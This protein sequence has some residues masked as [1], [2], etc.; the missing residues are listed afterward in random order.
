M[1]AALEAVRSIIARRTES[2][3]PREAA[4]KR[5]R[6]APRWSPVLR[7]PRKDRFSVRQVS[8]LL[9]RHRGNVRVAA[10][11]ARVSRATFY[12]LVK[13]FDLDPQRYQPRTAQR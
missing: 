6:A 7:G 4:R 5:G 11:V 8:A 10:S 9:A 12:R 3:V 2:G 13:R 1:T